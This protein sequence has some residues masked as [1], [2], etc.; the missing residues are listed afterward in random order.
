MPN[1]PVPATTA[2]TKPHELAG[3]RSRWRPAEEPRHPLTPIK[4]EALRLVAESKFLS[5]PQVAALT[6]KSEKAAR[7]H[8]SDLKDMR[9]LAPIPLPPA[10]FRDCDDPV[11][12]AYG[13]APNVWVPTRAGLSA[14][15]RAGMLPEGAKAPPAFRPE[16]F[17]FV[18]HEV[19]VRD[20][21][22]WLT[23][24]AR[25]HGHSV[26]TWDCRSGMRVGRSRPDAWFAYRAGSVYVGLVE[27]DMG[28]QRSRETWSNKLA[29]YAEIFAD[30]E[31]KALKEL[32]GGWGRARLVVTVPT[33]RR[34]AWIAE[35]AEERNASAFTWIAARPDL[36]GSDVYAVDWIRPG[37]EGKTPFAREGVL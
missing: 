21:L 8:L 18:A 12:A 3:R 19:A 31:R 26:E 25:K 5:T 22:C 7:D 10:A 14:L 28:T 9:L 17:A 36:K 34:A 27:V 30:T 29:S 11:A 6:G 16:N 33:E 1:T 15:R 35:L 13:S 24:S 23:A 37:G 2:S 4:L 32:T 20:T